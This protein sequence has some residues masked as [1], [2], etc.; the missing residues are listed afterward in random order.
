M[1]EALQAHRYVAAL[2]LIDEIVWNVVVHQGLGS[3]VGFVLCVLH[4][5][6]S[7][8][9]ALDDSQKLTAMVPMWMAQFQKTHGG[10]V[11]EHPR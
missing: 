7:I 11:T 8:A 2:G 4:C 10:S 9:S 1:A 6:D 5:I 3:V